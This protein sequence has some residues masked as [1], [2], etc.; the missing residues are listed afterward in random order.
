M[1]MSFGQQ[2]RRHISDLL[3]LSLSDIQRC[4]PKLIR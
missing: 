2:Q 1:R 3:L 4:Y